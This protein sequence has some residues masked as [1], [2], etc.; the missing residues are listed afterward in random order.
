VFSEEAIIE[1]N[2]RTWRPLL[3]EG[4]TNVHKEERSGR[5]NSFRWEILEYPPQSPEFEPTDL[6]LILHLNK[7]LGQPESEE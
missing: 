3:K 6:H 5:A 1:G 7:F 4:M 2:V